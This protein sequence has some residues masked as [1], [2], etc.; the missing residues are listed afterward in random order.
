MKLDHIK[1]S[2]LLITYNE[3]NHINEVIA[4]I[5]FANEIIV[6]DSYSNDG[7][8]EKLKK[9]NNVKVIQREF[10]NFA[11]QR[12]FAIDQANNNWILFI[13]AD[14]RITPGLRQEIL[15]KVNSDTESVAFRFPRQFIFQKKQ[16]KFSGLQTD[17][18]FRLFKKGTAKYREDRLVHELLDINGKTE[19]LN[20]KMLHYSFSNYES[21]KSKVEHYGKLKALE[22][23]NKGVKPNAFHFYFKPFYKFVSN[24]IFR[25]GFLDGKVGYNICKLNAYGVTCRYNEL[26]NLIKITPK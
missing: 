13:D 16:I 21:Y 24:F 18:I 22:L 26:K 10:K 17:T 7:T 3:V 8:Y 1:I 2:A 5:D 11:D 6:I 15:E 19:L 12:N 4:N 23:F 20:H 14:E 9:L 25:L